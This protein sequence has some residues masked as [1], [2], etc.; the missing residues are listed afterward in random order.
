MDACS[1]L[2]ERIGWGRVFGL[3]EARALQPKAPINLLFV[4][5]SKARRRARSQRGPEKRGTGLGYPLGKTRRISEAAFRT[6]ARARSGPTSSVGLLPHAGFRTGRRCAARARCR[7]GH[8]FIFLSGTITRRERAIGRNP[9][10]RDDYVLRNHL[11][12]LGHGGTSPGPG[13]SRVRR[14]TPR[15]A[16]PR[17]ARPP[18]RESSRRPAN[19]SA[20][21][22][23][24]AVSPP[25]VY[26]KPPGASSRG[27]GASTEIREKGAHLRTNLIRA[28]ARRSDRAREARP[29]AGARRRVAGAKN[30][31]HSGATAGEVPVSPGWLIAHAT[32]TAVCASST[33]F[34]PAQRHSAG[35]RKAYEAGASSTSPIPTG[36][37]PGSAQPQL[38][39]DRAEGRRLRTQGGPARQNLRVVVLKTSTASKWLTGT[40][41]AIGRGGGD[42]LLKLVGEAPVGALRAREATRWPGSATDA[43]ELLAA[44]LPRPT[45]FLTPP[46]GC[47]KRCGG[48]PFI[49]TA[50]EITWTIQHRGR[51]ATPRGR[52]RASTSAWRNAEAAMNRAKGSGRQLTSSYARRMTREAGTPERFRAGRTPLRTAV[53]Q[54][55]VSCTTAPGE[56][57]QN[58]RHPRA[59][60]P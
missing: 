9:P 27:R 57:V 53:A 20:C 25:T 21:P 11:V 54:K 48:R 40:V 46:Q 51:S 37:C 50:G 43:F 8:A 3:A 33:P 1:D 23:R 59:G 60:R 24:A 19:T 4:E 13:A 6:G 34:F 55:Q 12:R 7:T 30:G 41:T 38:L 32:R 18:G 29:A 16:A 52:A 42:A 45:I 17:G 35:R 58:G 26:L 36:P 15:A 10:R 22:T 47:A 5:D 31:D 56:T 44:V 39:G 14:S 49:R 28:W 2:R